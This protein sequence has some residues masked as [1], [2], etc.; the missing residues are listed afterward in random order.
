LRGSQFKA[1]ARL[2]QENKTKPTTVAYFSCSGSR[3][4]ENRG[5]RPAQAKM[6]VRPYLNQQAGCDGEYLSS[7]YE[8]DIM[9][10]YSKN[11]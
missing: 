6:L 1:T 11:N 7:S 4:P 2:S 9:R 10:L 5:S 8:G 3:D